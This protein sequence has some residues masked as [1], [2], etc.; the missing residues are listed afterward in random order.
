MLERLSGNLFALLPYLS[1]PQRRAVRAFGA[2]DQF[3]NNLRDL[4]EDSA[5]RLCYFPR[6]LLGKFELSDTHFY[7]GTALAHDGYVPFMRFWLDQHLPVLRARARRFLADGTVH[8]S[9][10]AMR[11][12]CL[13]R[14][15][16]ILFQFR[17]CNFDYE[18][19][20]RRYWRRVI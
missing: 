16:R 12:E 15:A 19:F 7:D 4:A 10:G 1:E 18:L 20:A 3:Y 13:G 14:Y 6:D 9:V 2:L 8:P 11:A 5:S 17:W